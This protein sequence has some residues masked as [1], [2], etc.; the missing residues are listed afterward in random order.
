MN[1]SNIISNKPKIIFAGAMGSGK[2]EIAINYA[3]FW[4]LQKEQK[5]GLIDLDMVKPYFRLRSYSESIKQDKVDLVA[6]FGKYLYADTP[7]IPP[8]LESYITDITRPAIIDVG[9]DEVGARLL[10]RY[11]S[12][13][14]Q[15]NVEF[16]YVYNGMRPLSRGFDDVA[17]IMDSIEKASRMKLTGLIHNSHLMYEST[18]D[19][20][21]DNIPRAEFFAKSKHLP[22]VFHCIK[23]DLFKDAA[24]TLGDI[25]ILPL[26]LHVNME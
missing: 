21:K 7:I 11:H 3:Y 14:K 22:I 8:S 2:T 1:I 24:N 23:E 15:E 4:N 16:W 12:R 13:L 5:P 19:I 25:P 18:V 17:E 10:G 26:K 9:G 6:P 20:L